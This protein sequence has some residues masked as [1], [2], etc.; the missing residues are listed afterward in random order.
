[1]LPSCVGFGSLGGGGCKGCMNESM[2]ICACI[3]AYMNVCRLLKHNRF[4]LTDLFS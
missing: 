1:M 4:I 3:H 2:H